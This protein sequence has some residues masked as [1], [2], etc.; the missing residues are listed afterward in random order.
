M[1]NNQ[2][3]RIKHTL[4]TRHLSMIALG[5]TIGT[6]LFIASGSA[7]TTAGPGGSLI[8]YLIMGV[9]VFFLMTSLAEM[10]TYN[11]RSGSF[12]EYAN[13][14][15]DPALGF[16]MG[17]NYWFCGAI[18]VA[19]ELSTVG[20]VMNFWFPEVA[21]WVF[22]IL[23]FV[24]IFTINYFSVRAY[25]ETEFWLAL[26]KVLAVVAFVIVGIGLIVGLIGGH[27]IGFK[28]FTYRQAPFV[29]GVP[30]IISAFVVSGFSFQGTEMVGIAAGE[31]ADPQHSVPTAIHATFWRILL[32]YILTIFVIA[33]VLPY[34]NK[35]LL[36]SDVQD[37][38]TSPF[39]LIFQYAGLRY[40]AG[41]LNFV[42]LIAVLSSANSWLYAISR[43]LFSQS[44]D[45]FLWHGFKKVNQRGVP[46]VSFIAMAVLSLA[47]WA[48]QFIG[49]NVYNY[50]IAATSLG[51]FMEWLGIAIA[52]Y[53]FRRGF[54]KQ[55]H[56]LDELSYHAGLFP[57]GPIF[58]FIL[59]IV[60]IAGQNVDAFLKLDW[61]NI[62][63]TY[64][65]VPL[66]I[67]F[68]VYYKLRHHTHLVPLDKM[69]LK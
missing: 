65:S 27:S 2:A 52:H 66:F 5:G 58:A 62:L 55:G 10:A 39:T 30:G 18:T 16:A 68:Y 67:A 47:L 29:N 28:N 69:K 9:M 36:S 48:L 33:C 15:V 45:G 17:W 24:I 14:Y 57:V 34:T 23:A 3:G 64:M 12:A 46:I 11:P 60:V 8:A 20:I 40:A 25:G 49:P 61:A 6:G 50:L 37:I 7:I 26:L 38:V 51:G 32:F 56:S 63:I 43:I 44:L 31:S 22:S 21:S 13:R 4:R 19:V 35:N 42:I 41:M 59:C 1:N 54:I 53:R